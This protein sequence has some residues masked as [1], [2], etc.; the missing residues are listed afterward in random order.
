M[1]EIDRDRL[2]RSVDMFVRELQS[3]PRSLE[4][5]Y[6][7]RHREVVTHEQRDNA[8]SALQQA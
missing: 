6:V 1:T 7:P 3:D 4:E 8:V 5:I 2:R